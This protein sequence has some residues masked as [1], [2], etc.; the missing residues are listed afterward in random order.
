MSAAPAYLGVVLIWSTTPMAVKL[1]TDTLSFSAAAGL[2]MLL[3]SLCCLLWLGIVRQRL[4]FDREALASY[5]AANIGVFGAMSCIYAAVTWVPSGLLS[6]I[7]GLA[8]VLSG[9]FARWLLGERTLSTVRVLALAI[10]LGGLGVVFRGTLGFAPE[11][12]PGLLLA[13]VAVTLFALSSVLV[14]RYSGNMSAAQHTAG[15]LLF[16]LPLFAAAWALSDGQLPLEFSAL[17]LGFVL[18]LAVIG[19]T[20]GFM[21]YFSIL[22]RLTVAQVTLI[23]L[24]TPVLA[25]LL[26]AVVLDEPVRADTVIG[27][28]LILGGLALYQLNRG[29]KLPRRRRAAA[30]ATVENASAAKG[31]A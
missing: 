12:W 1:S 24:A 16:S 3:A 10:A 14:K 13:L 26:G 7:F 8:P 15:S 5:A 31:R 18:Y 9:V 11:A 27:A 17:S 4:R 22:H 28:A 21:L 29:F 6:V 30:A 25:L 2:R 23:P 19:S 20:L